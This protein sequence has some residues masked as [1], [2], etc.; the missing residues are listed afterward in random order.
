MLAALKSGTIP[1]PDISAFAARQLQRVIGP[2]FIDF[3]GPVAQ[4]A[5]DKQA[6][7]AKFRRLLTDEFVSRANVSNGRVVFER[8][9]VACHTLYGQGGKIGPDITGSNRANLDYVLTETNVAAAVRQG[10]VRSEIRTWCAETLAPVWNG[11]PRDVLF[12]GYFA[13]LRP[14]APGS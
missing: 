7:I 11:K 13:C 3:W 1:K 2:A 4:P 12:H 14:T 10:A 5:E 6:D 8:T 9:C